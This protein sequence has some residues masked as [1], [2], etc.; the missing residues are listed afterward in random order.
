VNLILSNS[1]NLDETRI[2][3]F[4]NPADDQVTLNIGSH[5]VGSELRIIDIRGALVR[6]V[7]DLN[8]L[9]RIP[10]SDLPDGVYFIQINSG[11]DHIVQ[12]IIIQH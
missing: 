10:V 6:R 3:A 5:L 8:T 1:H 11:N 4:P 2:R 9:N 7:A 12:R